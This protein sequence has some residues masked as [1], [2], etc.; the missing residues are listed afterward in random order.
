MCNNT[1]KK[2]SKIIINK[3][4][5]KYIKKM[6]TVKKIKIKTIKLKIIIIIKSG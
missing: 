3:Q 4:Y 5:V 6:K 1:I 2:G